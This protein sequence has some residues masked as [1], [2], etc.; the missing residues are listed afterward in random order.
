MG[1][2]LS[3]IPQT[4]SLLTSSEATIFTCDLQGHDK[5]ESAS[6]FM[7]GVL[8][9][10]FLVA[11]IPSAHFSIGHF[12]LA[13]EMVNLTAREAGKCILLCTQLEDKGPWPSCL[14]HLSY[15]MSTHTEYRLWPHLNV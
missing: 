15:S 2:P 14:D 3:G 11:P 12:P 9:P 7:P 10:R 6:K 1:S 13:C 4:P 8:W 5:E